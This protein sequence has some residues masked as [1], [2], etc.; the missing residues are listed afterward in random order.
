MLEY[1]TVSMKLATIF[2]KLQSMK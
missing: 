2:H 1:N